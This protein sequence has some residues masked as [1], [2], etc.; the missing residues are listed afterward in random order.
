MPMG[1][2]YISAAQCSNTSATKAEIG[3]KI[4]STF[5]VIERAVKHIQTARQTNVLHNMP[6][7]KLLMKLRFTFAWA[8]FN[9][10]A[11]PDYDRQLNS[12]I[13]KL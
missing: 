8:I 13:D 4:T 6:L 1:I 12:L 5:A 11:P 9:A 3:N 2:K 10:V 7:V